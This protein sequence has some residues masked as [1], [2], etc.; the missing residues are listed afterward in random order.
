M[1]NLGTMQMHFEKKQWKHGN[2]PWTAEPQSA[3]QTT[4]NSV[5]EIHRSI[6]EGLSIHQT[7]VSQNTRQNNRTILD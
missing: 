5:V 7:K 4:I 6:H 2:Q 1:K 3:D